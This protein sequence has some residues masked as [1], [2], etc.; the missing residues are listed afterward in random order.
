MQVTK[1]THHTIKYRSFKKFEE[2][3]FIEDLQAIP[4]DVDNIF[5]DVDDALE[6]WYSLLFEVIDKPIPLKHHRVKRKNQPTWL[7]TEII[8]GIKVRDRFK[9]LGN[10]EQ[11]K[12]WRNKVVSLIKQSKK[13]QL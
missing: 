6:T 5:E 13:M 2:T 7:T 10:Q 11:Y 1:I 9:A 12:V 8:E 3:K 4:W